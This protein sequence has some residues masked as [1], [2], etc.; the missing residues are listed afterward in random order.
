MKIFV[1]RQQGVKD[2]VKNTTEMENFYRKTQGVQGGYK[3]SLL[4]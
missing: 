3:E 1:P 4:L 2:G